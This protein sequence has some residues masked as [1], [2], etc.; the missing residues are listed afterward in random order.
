VARIGAERAS[1][2]L[3]G[4][5]LGI[6]WVKND[7]EVRKSRLVDQPG[8]SIADPELTRQELGGAAHRSMPPL[9]TLNAALRVSF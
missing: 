6:L 3:S 2:S 8:L 4:R 7:G 1:L 9:T 5:E